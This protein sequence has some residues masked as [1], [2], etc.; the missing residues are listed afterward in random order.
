MVDI[1]MIMMIYDNSNYVDSEYINNGSYDNNKNND[2]ISVRKMKM[3]TIIMAM[4]VIVKII[5]CKNNNNDTAD[6]GFANSNSP[7]S[8]NDN[9]CY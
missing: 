1:M 3:K 2:M 9:G 6:D 7:V 4:I 5:E 8:N